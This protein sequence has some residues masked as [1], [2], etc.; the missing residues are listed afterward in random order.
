MPYQKYTKTIKGKKKFCI[1]N[2]QTGQETCY[3][4]EKKRNTGI[5][6]KEAFKHGFKLT[7]EKR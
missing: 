1:R 6:I 7:K 5:K 3:D 4:S 2:K